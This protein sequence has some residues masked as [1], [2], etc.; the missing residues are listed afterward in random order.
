MRGGTGVSLVSA[1]SGKKKL[2]QVIKKRSC[3]GA[4]RLGPLATDAARK[5]DVLGHDG[6]T[7][8]VD[9]AEVGVLEQANEVRLCGLLERTDGRGLEAQVGLVVLGNL[10]NQTLCT[11]AKEEW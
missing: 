8:G 6:D 7:L 2:P 3:T 1:C 5:L 4:H 10:T 11:G 9:R